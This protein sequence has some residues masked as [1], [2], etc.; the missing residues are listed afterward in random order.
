MPSQASPRR[1]VRRYPNLKRR[2]PLVLLAILLLFCCIAL[3]T[4]ASLALTPS[5]LAQQSAAGDRNL[6]EAVDPIPA[7]LQLSAEVYLEKCGTC[8]LALPPEVM[9][10]ETW[11][12][13]LMNPQDHYNVSLDLITPEILLIWRYLNNFSRALNEGESEPYRVADSRFFQ[14]LHP[15]VEFSETPGL[16]TCATC[17]NRAAEFNFRSLTPE[18]LDAS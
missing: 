16:E 8:H 7:D 3:G 13:L 12:Q 2:S 11:R 6:L 1:R 5:H 9:P 14:A 4:T 17:H 18:W 15:R 10:S